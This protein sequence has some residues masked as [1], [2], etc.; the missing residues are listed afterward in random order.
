MAALAY[1]DILA[2][3]IALPAQLLIARRAGPGGVRRW[4]GALC[5]TAVACVP[6]LV[7]AIIER[8]RRDAIYWLPKPDRTL[9]S[10]TLQEFTGGFSEVTAVRWLTIVAALALV[11]G[12]L[13]VLL[14][15]RRAQGT[16][17]IAQDG[18]TLAIAAAWGLL[19]PLLLLVVSFA[20]P[21]FWPRYA[22]VAL[23][24]L[25]L[26]VASAATIVWRS[27]PGRL[28][29]IAA[30]ACIAL[31]VGVALF[32]DVR[33]RT[34]Q[35]ENWP[36]AAAW[37]AAQRRVGE[38]TILDNVIVLPVLG[39]YD[40]AFRAPDGNVVVQE[41]EDARVPAGVVG[42][43]DPKGYGSVANGPPSAADIAA[44]A[45][46]GDGTVWIVLSEVDRDLQ[47]DPRNGAAVA[48]A[49]SHC[50]VTV[51]ESVGVWVMRAA[52]CRR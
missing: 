20:H 2:A 26:L 22:I 1:C 7:A 31:I 52:A 47:G 48:W 13:V 38:P 40:H 45:R 34:K 28:G 8:S 16:G 51:R 23:P 17:A 27:P 9:L 25:C 14:A 35:Q 24:G 12:A 19:G 6:L 29:P 36:P 46:T 33:Q 3:P 42:F 37:L 21:L 50:S 30:A 49:R 44:L 32:A 10:T 18:W 41:W 15:R 39:Y 5:A 4:L 11:A 43:K